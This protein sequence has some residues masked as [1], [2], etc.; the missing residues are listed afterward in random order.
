MAGSREPTRKGATHHQ[1]H[2]VRGG[3]IILRTRRRRWIFLSGLAG[4]GL[5]ALLLGIA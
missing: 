2:D 4:A 3:E 1:A 5:L